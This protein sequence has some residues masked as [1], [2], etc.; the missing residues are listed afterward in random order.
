MWIERLQDDIDDSK[1][2]DELWDAIQRIQDEIANY[3]E[4]FDEVCYWINLYGGPQYA[5]CGLFDEYWIQL[6]LQYKGE[7]T[8]R[9]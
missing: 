2:Q 1:V 3:Y 9:M 8:W 4:R 5:S 6:I 7:S